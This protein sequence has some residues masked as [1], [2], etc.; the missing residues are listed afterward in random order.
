MAK[1]KTNLYKLGQKKL[2]DILLTEKL[3]ELDTLNQALQQGHTMGRMLEEILITNSTLNDISL[4]YILTSQYQV[5]YISLEHYE[6]PN[7]LV[8]QYKSLMVKYWFVPLA[9]FDRLL[10][11]A[12]ATSFPPESIERLESDCDSD[13]FAY[14][15]NFNHLKAAI[16]K[17]VPKEEQ[18]IMHTEIIKETVQSPTC[19]ESLFDFAD[20]SVRQEL[21]EKSTSYLDGADEEIG[22]AHV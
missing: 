13:I 5:P 7:D 11:I 14:I 15:G 12:V 18:E 4:A 10:T 19:W 22:R 21:K 17:Y 3:V 16:D 2:E 20:E 9:R 8:E 6:I 1:N